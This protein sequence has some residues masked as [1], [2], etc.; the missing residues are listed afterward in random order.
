MGFV[1]FENRNAIKRYIPISF[2]SGL[3]KRS[4]MLENKGDTGCWGLFE[5]REVRYQVPKKVGF[6][7]DKVVSLQQWMKKLGFQLFNSYCVL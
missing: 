7:G 5:K 6:R 1:R 3:E 4:E 2:F